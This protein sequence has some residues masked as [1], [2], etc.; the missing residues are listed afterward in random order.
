MISNKNRGF[1]YECHESISKCLYESHYLLNLKI[2]RTNLLRLNLFR[3][4]REEQCRKYDICEQEEYQI[5]HREKKS[6][7]KNT[8]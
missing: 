1:T 3:Y 5:T 2:L 6:K 4:R 7:H 8:H